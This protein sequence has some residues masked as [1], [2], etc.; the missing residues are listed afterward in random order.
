MLTLESGT[1]AD[2]RSSAKADLS[3]TATSLAGID[4]RTSGLSSMIL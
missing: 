3:A 2:D 4:V 1:D